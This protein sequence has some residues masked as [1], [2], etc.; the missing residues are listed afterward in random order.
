MKTNLKNTV[1]TFFLSVG[2]LFAQSVTTVRATNSDISDNLDLQAVASIFGD[3]ADLEDFEQRLND[4]DIQISNLDLNG[5]NRVDY[6]RVVELSQSNTHVI[7]LQAV[8][9]IDTYQDVATVEVERDR[10]NN[11]SV[12]VVGDP[13]IYG[14]SYIYEPVYVVTPP[15]FDIFWASSYRPYYSPWYW[16]YYPT[17]YS[18]WT[19]CPV[20]RYRNHV[21][22]HINSRNSYNYVN[23]RHSSRAAAMYAPRRSNA[24]ER[25]HP[26]NSFATRNNNARNHY[27]LEQSRSNGTSVRGGRTLNSNTG[28]RNDMATGSRSNTNSFSNSSR[29]NGTRT[30]NQSSSTRSNTFQ[31]QGVN[32]NNTPAATRTN[33]DFSTRSNNNYGTRNNSNV[34]RSQGTDNN[35]ST[36]ARNYSTPTRSYDT[37]SRN[38]NS[39]VRSTAPARSTVPQATRTSTPSTPRQSTPSAPARSNG[40]GGS[41][42]RG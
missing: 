33:S 28:S 22:V 4:P 38:N 37:P 31:Y 19:P 1:L 3:S 29:Q 16:G 11:V 41:R 40:N 25:Q 13:Y 23:V 12:Q 7:V 6:L 24:Y 21:H 14:P 18:Y 42:S 35:Y 39:N 26:G 36:P 8:L 30:L 17:Y 34:V 5:D 10:Y 20:Y 27:D 2:S 15:V 32:N 9:G